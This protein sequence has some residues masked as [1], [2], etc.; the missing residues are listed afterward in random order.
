MLPIPGA[1]LAAM[2]VPANQPER[3]ALEEFERKL[4]EMRSGRRRR[5][6]SPLGA[7]DHPGHP[8]H[9][10][11]RRRRYQAIPYTETVTH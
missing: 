7:R 8:G 11:H 2:G 1:P 5:S 10:L 6:P 3:E 4:S 9:H